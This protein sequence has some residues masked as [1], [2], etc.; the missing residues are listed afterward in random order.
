M[1]GKRLFAATIALGMLLPTACTFE[2]RRNPAGEEPTWRNPVEI[3]LWTYPVGGWGKKSSVSGLIAD[4]QQEHPEIR[5]S[6]KTVDYTTGDD[7]VNEAIESGEMPDLIFEGPERLVANWGARGLMVPLNDLWEDPCSAE[8]YDSVKVACHDGEENYYEYPLCMTT[9]CMAINRTLFEETGAWQY[10]NEE[11]HTWS[12]DDFFHAVELLHAAGQEEVC[13]VFCGGQGGDQGTRAL[14]TN[15]GGGTFTDERHT[16]YT[17]NSPENIAALTRLKNAAGVVFDKELVGSGEIEKFCRGELAMVFCWN[18]SQEIQQTLTYE[19]DFDI[20]PM[21]FPTDMEKPA[22][23]GGIWGFGIFDNG[24]EA[25]IKAAKEFIRFVAMD[26]EVHARA[27]TISTYS[28]VCEMPDLYEG[29]V[30]MNEY[31]IFNKYLGDYYQVTPNWADART[32]WWN[33]LQQIGDGMPAAEAVARFDEIV[34]G[35]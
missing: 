13:A 21:A 9:H 2:R 5:V 29:D 11:T 35:T 12:S 24:S 26:E 28:P 22:L 16:C 10:V 32:A 19:L 30:L 1:K 33:M 34:N 25:R 14:V 17:V 3:S 7:E 6:I 20:F 23:Q 15:L 4:F 27:V 31:A 8:I 18:V